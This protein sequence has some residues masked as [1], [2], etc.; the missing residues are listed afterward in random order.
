MNATQLNSIIKDAKDNF[1]ND[2]VFRL[3]LPHGG[4]VDGSIELLNPHVVK[5]SKGKS[6][7][8]YVD[9]EAVVCVSV[10]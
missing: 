10:G 2:L 8:Q 6:T 9:I 1:G 5:V 7:P 3:H 4:Y